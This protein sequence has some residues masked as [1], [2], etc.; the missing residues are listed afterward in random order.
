VK[1][2][3]ACVFSKI[4]TTGEEV[5]D[6]GKLRDMNVVCGSQIVLEVQCDSND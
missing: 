4:K 5:C 2:D 1:C 3:H 6:S